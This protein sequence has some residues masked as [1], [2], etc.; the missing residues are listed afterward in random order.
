MTAS[1]LKSKV[2]LYI[3][4]FSH[5]RRI[6]AAPTEYSAEYSVGAAAILRAREKHNMYNRTFDFSSDA[7]RLEVFAIEVFAIGISSIYHLTI[8]HLP[9]IIYR[10][11]INQ[12]SSILHL[13]IFYLSS[14]CHLLLSNVYHPTNVYHLTIYHQGR[15]KRSACNSY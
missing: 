10:L 2:R 1:L 8:Y 13:I 9:S 14:L 15:M 6:A 4:C 11:P 5:A 3:S 7:V 12:L